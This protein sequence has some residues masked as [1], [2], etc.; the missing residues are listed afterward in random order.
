[1][2]WQRVALNVAVL[3]VALVAWLGRYEII[4]VPAGGAG[5]HGVVYRL[6]RW[7]GEVVFIQGARG[8]VAE[9]K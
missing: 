3:V 1:M 9:I 5:T 6:D 2:D 7:T 4:G 8:G